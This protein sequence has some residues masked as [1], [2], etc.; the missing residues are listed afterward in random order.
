MIDDKAV[1]N[2][3]VKV[4]RYTAFI[5]FLNTTNEESDVI[6]PLLL[7]RKL[8]LAKL[9]EIDEAKVGMHVMQRYETHCP[10]P[11]FFIAKDTDR[12]IRT[13]TRRI[14]CHQII[15]HMAG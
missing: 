15:K 4:N 14:V 13:T 6:Y 11:P 12:H 2:I 3:L 8:Q 7:R 10:T 5:Y 1:G 9:F